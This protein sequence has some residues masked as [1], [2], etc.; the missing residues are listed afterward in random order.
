MKQYLFY[1]VLNRLVPKKYVTVLFV[2]AV[3]RLNLDTID[4]VISRDSCDAQ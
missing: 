2:A 3:V 4:K 1:S